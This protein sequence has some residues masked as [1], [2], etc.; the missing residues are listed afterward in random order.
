MSS[1]SNP[2][3]GIKY[4]AII[5]H[6]RQSPHTQNSIINLN[7]CDYFITMFLAKMQQ[8]YIKYILLYFL[9][10][11]ISFSS[12]VFSEGEVVKKRLDVKIL[13]SGKLIFRFEQR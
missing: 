4:T 6:D 12:K 7:L 8:L 2:I 1:E 3:H 9:C 10:G 11:M 5:E 13:I